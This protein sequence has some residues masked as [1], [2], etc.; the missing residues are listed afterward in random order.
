M[1]AAEAELCQRECEFIPEAWPSLGDARFLEAW[2]VRSPRMVTATMAN[3]IAIEIKSPFHLTLILYLLFLSLNT[4]SLISSSLLP[5][6]SPFPHENSI[7]PLLNI[8]ELLIEVAS[9][10]D[11][12]G[13]CRLLQTC[14]Q[15]QTILE[16][17]LF[18]TLDFLPTTP[19]Y[20]SARRLLSTSTQ[21]HVLKR[22]IQHVHVLR[23][24]SISTAFLF[25][26]FLS[27]ALHNDTQLSTMPAWLPPL[28][29]GQDSI[30]PP[31]LPTN[32]TF[33]RGEN[34]D[35]NR[36]P[37]RMFLP[38]CPAPRAFCNCVGLFRSIHCSLHW[39]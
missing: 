33:L 16:P 18:R 5:P 15:A 36:T 39:N 2:I 8:R 34:V 25:N 35:P 10:L 1:E 23:T 7:H 11:R 32:L 31:P 14:H 17:N 6:P 3:E 20:T 27:H 4:I 37:R 24:G 21:L 12:R 26:C 13:I 30:V 9:L 19:P 38:T 29:K 22:N 28:V